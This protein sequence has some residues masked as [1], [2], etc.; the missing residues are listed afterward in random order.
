MHPTRTA[1]A[2][3]IASAPIHTMGQVVGPATRGYTV[4]TDD[5]LVA[6]RRAASCLL[7]PEP[8]DVVLLSGQSVDEAYIIAVLER[9]GGGPACLTFNGDTVLSVSNGAL[10]LAAEGGMTLSTPGDMTVSSDGL[11]LRGRQATVL[12]QRLVA[13]GQE[14]SASVGRMKLVGNLL[15]SVVERVR[16]SARH[17]LRTVEDL[18]QVRSGTVDYRADQLMSLRGANVVATARE[19]VKLDGQQI[20]V[21]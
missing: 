17:S 15:E 5:D 1:A 11:T 7:E 13:V 9:A 6:A 14:V 12:L 8:G 19:L 2:T 16:Q 20:H 10:S 18:D 21:G 3:R 4:R